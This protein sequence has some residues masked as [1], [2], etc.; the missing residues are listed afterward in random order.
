MKTYKR[1]VAGALLAGLGGLFIWGVFNAEAADAARFLT[2]P[3]FTFAAGAFGLDALAKQ[4]P[5]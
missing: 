2:I 4:W 3:V 1:E 5:R